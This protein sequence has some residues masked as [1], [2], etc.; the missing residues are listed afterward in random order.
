ML[1]CLALQSISLFVHQIHDL[2]RHTQ[3]P[4]SAV[5]R[6]I[7]A[8]QTCLPVAF[9]CEDTPDR[10]HMLAYSQPLGTAWQLRRV[11]Q[12]IVKSSDSLSMPQALASPVSRHAA[13]LPAVKFTRTELPK[14]LKLQSLLLHPSPQ[15]SCDWAVLRI[16]RWSNGLC[17]MVASPCQPSKLCCGAAHI[18]CGLHRQHSPAFRQHA[19]VRSSHKQ[20]HSMQSK[21][22]LH[23]AAVRVSCAYLS[24]SSTRAP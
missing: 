17:L 7:T 5:Q 6:P 8:S 12:C 24:Q 16:C 21:C 3:R 2:A 1:C 14:G 19:H 11:W 13:V 4:H 22:Q 10:C 18:A 20:G 15:L 23:A 9:P